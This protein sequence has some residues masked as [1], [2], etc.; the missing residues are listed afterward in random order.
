M[1]LAGNASD[2]VGVLT[3]T[4]TNAATG[5]FGTVTGRTSWTIAN[6]ALNVGPNLIT[7]TAWDLVGNSG[8]DTLTITRDSTAPYCSVNSPTATGSYQT[9]LDTVT[10]GGNASDDTDVVSVTWRNGA[11]GQTGTAN[12][13]TSWEIADIVLALGYNN[14]T[15]TAHDAA[16]NVGSDSIVVN[17]DLVAPICKI[18]SPTVDPTYVTNGNSISLAGTASDN[19]GVVSVTWSNDRGGSGVAMGTTGWTISGITLQEGNNTITVTATDAAGNSHSVTITVTY[20]TTAIPEFSDFVIVVLGMMLV[21]FLI[22]VKRR[23]EDE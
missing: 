5:A 7:V 19:V 15:V 17:Y 1:N 9:R 12:G 16:G 3:V 2:D 22:R 21:F 10:I 8:S 23:K 6:V 13:T 14:I 18:T 20:T 11:T 4:W